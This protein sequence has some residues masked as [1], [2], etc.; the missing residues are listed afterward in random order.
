MNNHTHYFMCTSTTHSCLLLFVF[1][2]FSVD[3]C[4]LPALKREKV[5]WGQIRAGIQK[6]VAKSGWIHCRSDYLLVI[7]CEILAISCSID[8]FSSFHAFVDNC[9]SIWPTISYVNSLWNSP[10][11]HNQIW[12]RSG[13]QF[14]W[15]AGNLLCKSEARKRRE[16]SGV[17]PKNNHPWGGT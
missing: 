16:F 17:W 12:A 2:V 3:V 8:C 9:S 6:A 10:V 4:H 7:F 1:W 14:V 13:K 5:E 11:G 15:D